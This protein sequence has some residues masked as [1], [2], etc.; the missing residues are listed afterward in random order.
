MAILN[1]TTLARVKA[2]GEL[3]ATARADVDTAL[4][5]MIASVSDRFQQYCSRGLNIES[6][7]ESRV[8]R[9][10]LFPVFRT[11]VVSVAQVR[12]S[13]SG[14]RADLIAT[15]DFEINAL[16][17]GVN[18]WDVPS[19]TLVEVTY[20][21]GVASTA[22][23][24]MALYPSIAEA[25]T[26]QVVNLWQRRKSPDKTGLTM[27]NGDIRWE[28]RYELLKEAKDALDQA[29]NNDHRFL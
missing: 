7:V 11:P 10:T 3:A 27:G 28:G 17:N 18:V 1:L 29:F 15:T 26:L 4:T 5:E 13:T 20:T 23:A 21:G 24:F 6:A 25:A 14:R 19:G 12:V 2:R 22:D 9:G 8:L 16:G